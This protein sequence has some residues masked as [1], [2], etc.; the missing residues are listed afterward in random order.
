MIICSVIK[1][2]IGATGTVEDLMESMT[3]SNDYLGSVK[4]L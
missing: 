1:T 2:T 3:Q 4:R